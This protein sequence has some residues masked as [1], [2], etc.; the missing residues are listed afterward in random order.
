MNFP[1]KGFTMKRRL[2]VQTC[3]SAAILGAAAC[4]PVKSASAFTWGES[5]FLSSGGYGMLGDAGNTVKVSDK[6]GDFDEDV[7][8]AGAQSFIDNLSKRALNFLSDS[9]MTQAQKVSKFENLLDDSFDMKTISRFSLGRYW[10]VSS[11]QQRTEYYELFR[12]MVLDVYSKR[13]SEYAGQSFE[14]GAVR[15]AGPSDYIVTSMIIDAE[16][17]HPS[18]QVDWRVRYKNDR[19]QVIDIIVEGVSMAVTQR[20]DFSSVIQRGGGDV[21]ALINH[22]K[23]RNKKTESV[24]TSQKTKPL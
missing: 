23:S 14:T 1:D 20:S 3:I 7:V 8:S 17:D 22:L 13:F 10:R 5:M 12:R 11:K 16:G 24:V 9:E 6:A 15:K 4:L 19:Y 18:V 21:Q 2:L